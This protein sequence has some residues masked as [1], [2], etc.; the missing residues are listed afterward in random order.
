MV[1]KL[2]EKLAV[3]YLAKKLHFVH[4]DVDERII[5]KWTLEN[6]A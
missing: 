6:L 1:P 5:L 2:L 3:T 4:L